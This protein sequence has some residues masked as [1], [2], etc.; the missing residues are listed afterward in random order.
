MTN[1]QR[2]GVLINKINRDCLGDTER[3]ELDYLLS[4]SGHTIRS[5]MQEQRVANQQA[6]A[7]ERMGSN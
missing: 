4:Q 2:I 3:K 5:Y 7:M 6:A 1:E